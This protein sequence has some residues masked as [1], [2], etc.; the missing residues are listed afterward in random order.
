MCN[1]ELAYD[2]LFKSLYDIQNLSY[3]TPKQ[4]ILKP[5]SGDWQKD[6]SIRIL[7]DDPVSSFESHRVT[8]QQSGGT[9]IVNRVETFQSGVLSVTE[10]FLTQIVGTFVVGESVTSNEVDG[11]SGTGIVQGVVT[12]ID[13]TSSGT[14]YKVDDRLTFS[15]GGGIDAKAKITSVGTGALTT[16]TLFDGGDGYIEG[17]ALTVNNFATGGSGFAGKISDVIDSF[18]FSRNDDKSF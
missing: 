11:V 1:N 17:K 3:Y 16:F 14:N 4:D 15:G 9:G 12:G 2:F 7:T 18:S 13:I 10:L 8:G 5:S 6:R